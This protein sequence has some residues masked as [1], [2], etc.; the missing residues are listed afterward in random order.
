MA[1]L[2]L[3][4]FDVS[5][6]TGFLP[7]DEPERSLPDRF[8]P[9]EDVVAQLP[10]LLSGN[11]LRKKVHGLPVISPEELS[12]LSEREWWRAYVLLCYMCHAY[13]WGEGEKNISNVLPENL[14]I[15]WC[16]VA[17]HVGLPPVIT[18]CAAVLHNWQK[19]HPSGPLSG[20]NMRIY[21]SFT[22]TEDENW[23]SIATALVELEAAKGLHVIPLVFQ[24]ITECNNEGLQNSL[25]TVKESISLM[26]KALTRMKER[27]RPSVFYSQL[28]QFLAG[29]K[30]NSVL[31]E[32]L[33]YRGVSDVPVQFGGGSAAQSS[34]MAAFDS[35]LGVEHNGLE[36]EFLMEQRIHMPPKHRRFLEEMKTQ[37]SLPQYIHKSH[38]IPVK[39][40]YNDCLKAM[41]SLR[42]E[43][44]RIVSLYI[45]AQNHHS[46]SGLSSLQ[47]SGTGG[48]RFMVFLKNVR[49]NTEDALIA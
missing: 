31:P 16:A 46:A 43:H 15:P 44:I 33:V 39:E 10:V 38:S 3:R 7:R 36:K 32:G 26:E 28:R 14:S 24:C 41:V 2:D 23:F 12:C 34:T 40:A 29:W 30:G 19:V 27:C 25:T 35:L 18:H 1:T 11:C 13:V 45:V 48:T 42:S 37:P 6:E 21:A 20:D 17:K 5:D 22:G 49:K 4:F 47:S 8:K 9:W